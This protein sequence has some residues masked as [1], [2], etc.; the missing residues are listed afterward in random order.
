MRTLNNSPQN[1]TLLRGHEAST[2]HRPTTLGG[3][4]R[5]RNF[6]RIYFYNYWSEEIY[7]GS[8]KS[9]AVFARV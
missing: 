5:G 7:W 2:T 9:R 4:T 6:S 3:L 8:P 1:S